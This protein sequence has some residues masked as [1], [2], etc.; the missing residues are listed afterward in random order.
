MNTT[1]NDISVSV[2]IPAYNARP[3]VGRAIES[4]LTQEPP[5]H[6]VIVINDGSD[7]GTADVARSY[8]ERITLIEQANQGQ[9]AARNAGLKLATGRFVA[10]LDADDYW[11]PGFLRA[12]VDFLLEHEDAMA[13]STG[14][15]VR[16]WGKPERRCP[17]AGA[18]MGPDSPFRPRVLENF[19]DF[20][21]RYDH[22]RTGA[23]LI[24]REVIERAGHQ[25]ADLRISQDLE[26]WAYLATWGKWGFIPDHLWIGDAAVAA[27]VQGWNRKYRDRRRLCPTIEQWESRILP[28]LAPEHKAGFEQ[29]RGRVAAHYALSRIKCGSAADAWWIVS[30]YGAAMPVSWSTKLMRWGLRAGYPGRKTAEV[31]IRMRERYVS[32]RINSLGARG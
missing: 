17:P 24:R 12:T 27:A 9:G 18:P 2:I 10:F 20:W 26:Y 4:A 29:V 11:A 6:E 16:L 13:V 7:D 32:M 3:L 25:R 28:R 22:M 31:L 14:I 21:A 23:A 19:F 5:P 15:V 1:S 8:G 30:R